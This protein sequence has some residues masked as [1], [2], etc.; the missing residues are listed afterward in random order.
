[1]NEKT[2]LDP[3]VPFTTVIRSH[4]DIFDIRFTEIFRYWDLV[5]ML[6]KRNVMLQY[7][8]TALGV[9]WLFLYPM[10]TSFVFTFVFGNFAGFSTGGTPAF[11]F[12]LASNSLWWVFSNTISNTSRTYRS[13]ANLFQKV[14]FPR[15][16]PPLAQM[17]TSFFSFLIRFG[18][19]VVAFFIYFFTTGGLEITW[20]WLL[21]PLPVLQAGMLGLGIGLIITSMTGEYRDMALVAD[22]GTQLLLYATPV[23]Y[24]FSSTKGL[25]RTVLFINPLSSIIENFRY[26]LFGTGEFMGLSWLISWLITLLLLV[27]GVVYYGNTCKSAIDTI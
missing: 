5:V 21:L 24:T 26:F 14:Y 7:K 4:T 15:L 16:A 8:Q 25:M 13:N 19:I 9:A 23:L 11:L 20:R 17:L 12:Y 6:F 3:G 22:F 18:M 27:F 2:L 1:M 10:V